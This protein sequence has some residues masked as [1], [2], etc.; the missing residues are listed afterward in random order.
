[1]GRLAPLLARDWGPLMT[2]YRRG[3]YHA[4]EPRLGDWLLFFGLVLL[5]A[6]GLA[7]GVFIL[8]RLATGR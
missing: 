6:S 8:F 5:V 3:D 1:M 4:A 2:T 7:L